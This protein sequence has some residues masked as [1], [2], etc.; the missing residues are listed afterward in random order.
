MNSDEQTILKPLQSNGASS[1]KNH[2]VTRLVQKFRHIVN[3]TYYLT[4]NVMLNI[5]H[6]LMGS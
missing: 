6:R 1:D 3:H 2:A 5:T 4:S